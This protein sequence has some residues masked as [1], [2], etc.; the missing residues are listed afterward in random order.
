M[1]QVLTSEQNQAA[2]VGGRGAAARTATPEEAVRGDTADTT[3]PEIVI[4]QRDDRSPPEGTPSKDAVPPP[5][6]LG[7][8]AVKERRGNRSRN[9]EAE[10]TSTAPAIRQPGRERIG[11]SQSERRGQP[12][13]QARGVGSR[14]SSPAARTERAATP[15]RRLP[16][17]SPQPGPAHLPA[18]Q[19]RWP[20]EHQR[21]GAAPRHTVVAGGS[22][23]WG[24]ACTGFI[25][26]CLVGVV[27]VLVYGTVKSLSHQGRVIDDFGNWTLVLLRR[28]RNNS[29][30][31]SSSDATMVG[32]LH[33][34]NLTE[35]VVNVTHATTEPP[36]K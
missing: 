6:E 13:D 4:G 30:A 28:A 9:S 16:L 2:D 21:P 19:G 3:P 33:G 1:G 17:G 25:V 34:R 11:G 24:L 35:G 32:G 7:D 20:S 15:G 5:V 31:G 22:R 23:K 8:I 36:R 14:P 27:G 10:L 18:T 29:D 12:R 26:G